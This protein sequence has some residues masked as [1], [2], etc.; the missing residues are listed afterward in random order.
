M[1]TTEYLFDGPHW[2]IEATRGFARFFS[3]LP[4]LV[5][6]EA[7]VCLS[8]GEWDDELKSFL[9]RHHVPAPEG[10]ICP[11]EF[12]DG[13]H[14]PATA[15]ALHELAQIAGH[16]AE[17]EI[18]MYVAISLQSKQILEMFDA[19]CDPFS[20]S[21]SIPE[22]RVQKFCSLAGVQYRKKQ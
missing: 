7:T 15:E 13:A 12:L 6:P 17:P 2:E 10:L 14:I 11:S 22:E 16:H 4:A 9:Q 5:P 18:A 3:A 21:L 8:D 1:N 19:T 20:V